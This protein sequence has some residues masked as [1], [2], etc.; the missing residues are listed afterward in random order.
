MTLLVALAQY[1]QRR[2]LKLWCC[3]QERLKA[4]QLCIADVSHWMAVNRL[5]LNPDKTELLSAGSK[6]G[7]ALLGSRGPP[8]Q[9]G[10][11]ITASD[12]VRLL[13][14]T[15]SS[16]LSSEKHVSIT[17]LTCFY[18]LHQLQQISRSLNTESAKTLVHRFVTSRIVYCNTMLAGSPISTIDRL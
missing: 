16:D 6:Y 18:W 1:D 4:A 8:L 15:I 7:R 3:R 12:H 13:T 5:K 9:L 17:S 10:E 2:P 11:I 14:V